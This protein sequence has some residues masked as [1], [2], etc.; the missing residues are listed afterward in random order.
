MKQALPLAALLFPI[1]ALAQTAAPPPPKPDLVLIPRQVVMGMAQSIQGVS[2]VR[3]EIA[4][5]TVLAPFRAAMACVAD[6][7]EDGRIMRQGQDECPEVTAALAERDKQ[8]A[9]AKA[10]QTKAEA[11]AAD[12]EAKLKAATTKPAAETATPDKAATPKP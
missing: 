5:P 6:N 11:A 7:P 8:I 2:I 10:A 9:D 4:T 3:P 1:A 12:A